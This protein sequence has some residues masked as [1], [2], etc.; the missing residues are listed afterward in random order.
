MIGE[1]ATK[2]LSMQAYEGMWLANI[3]FLPIAIFLIYKAK[4]DAVLFDFTR[5]IL[6]FNRL[7]K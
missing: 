1:K 6:V 5:L 2:E 7:K 4:N 3:A